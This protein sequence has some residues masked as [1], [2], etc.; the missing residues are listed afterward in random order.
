MASRGEPSVGNAAPPRRGQTNTGYNNKTR[1]ER[2]TRKTSLGKIKNMIKTMRA[3]ASTDNY[4]ERIHR[5]DALS[6]AVD[7]FTKNS[8]KGGQT[9]HDPHEPEEK[10]EEPRVEDQ[11]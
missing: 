2:S 1:T 10:I 8:N 11:M 9:Q 4:E 7:D 3:K 6:Q 5:I